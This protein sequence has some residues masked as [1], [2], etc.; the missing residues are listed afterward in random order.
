MTYRKRVVDEQLDASLASSGAVAIEGAKACGKTE[1]ALQRAASTVMLDIDEQ[2]YLAAQVNPSLLLDGPGPRLIDEWQLVP[3]IWN[4]V[5]REVDRRQAK[6]QFILTGSA[7]PIDDPKRHTGAGRFSILR[8]RPMSMYEAGHGTGDISLGCLLDGEPAR[9][10]N[11]A[12]DI[13]DLAEIIAT[14]GWPAHQGLPIAA[15]TRAARDYLTNIRDVDIARVDT[16][17]RDRTRIAALMASVARNVSTV[18]SHRALAADTGAN[19]DPMDRR[20]VDAYLTVLE[21]LMVIEDQPAWQPHLRSKSRLRQG[22]KRHYVDPSLA[23]AALRGSAARLTKDLNFL[24]LLFESL[25]I[26]DLRIYAGPLDGHVAHYRDSD[27]LEV[28]AVVHLDDGR[29]GAFEV[30]LGGTALIDA[31]AASLLKFRDRIDTAKSGAPATLGV[32]VASGYGYRRDD[33]IDVIP[34]GALKP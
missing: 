15:A 23:V 21:R 32:V 8:M 16:N 7:T 25:V 24:G 18:V 4:H 27:G 2:A 20:T 30:K 11:V 26:R 14:G 33:G 5:R 12:L 13:P 34:V 9:S 22:P 10:G 29:W 31:G 28:D 1:T 19:G 6:G 3:D 17:R